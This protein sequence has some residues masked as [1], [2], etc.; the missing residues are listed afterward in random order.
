MSTHYLVCY[1]ISEDDIRFTVA[2]HC[3]DIGLVRIQYSVFYGRLTK[4][5]LSQLRLQLKSSIKEANA[6]IHIIKVC[7]Q[8]EKSHEL[9]TSINTDLIQTDVEEHSH[10][11]VAEE[12]E[13][14][15][16]IL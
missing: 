11:E 8:C 7:D 13:D 1:D 12:F 14:T 9:L 15:V 6:D 16:M 5:K 3:K 10:Q 4:S 2:D